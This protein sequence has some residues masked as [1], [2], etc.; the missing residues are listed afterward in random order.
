M[1][2]EFN[3]ETNALCKKVIPLGI[4][5]M[6]MPQFTGSVI[7][8]FSDALQTSLAFKTQLVTDLEENF[9]QPLQSFVKIQL[10]EFKEFKKQHEKCLERYETQ[11]VKYV[12]QVKTKE[13]SAI[14]EEAFRLYE[15]RKIYAKMSSQHV[16]RV[17]HF[18]SL[19]EHFLVERFTLGTLYHLQDMKRGAEAWA[20][21][22]SNV[23]SW[24]QWLID[25]RETCD[26]QLRQLQYARSGLESAYL[27]S[28]RPVRE[29]EK[30]TYQYN[31]RHSMDLSGLNQTKSQ[32]WGY[33]FMKSSRNSWSRR[34][35]FLYEG[36]FGMTGRSAKGTVLMSDRVSIL[37]CDVKPLIDLDR[38]FCFEVMCVHQPS[39]VLQAET[40]QEMRD[41][42][43][44]FEKSKRL[45]LQNKELGSVHIQPKLE[46][47]SSIVLLSS[48]EKSSSL[49]PLL[50]REAASLESSSPL[51]HAWG[52]PWTSMPE[53][54]S[55]LSPTTSQEWD[56]NQVVWPLTIDDAALPQVDLVGYSTD[57]ESC[58]K[59]LRSLFGGVGA[60]E[61]VL[62][63][64]V[65]VLKRP[66]TMDTEWTIQNP[67]DS[68]DPE[69]DAQW[70]SSPKEPSSPLG[71]SYTGKGY[72]TQCN[73]WFYSCVALNCVN[74]VAVGLSDI[75]SI[76]VIDSSNIALDL[77]S[78]QQEPLIFT[79]LM[80]RAHDIATKLELAMNYVKSSQPSLQMLYDNIHGAQRS[81]D[82]LDLT[83][84]PTDKKPR[85]FSF[86]VQPKTTTLMATAVAGG[87]GSLEI[88]ESP[89]DINAPSG[90]VFCGCENHLDKLESEIQLPISANELYQ[91]LF[92]ENKELWEKKTTGN[93]SRDLTMT[94]WDQGA[95]GIE[96][97]LKYI[98]PVNNSM[99]K[100]KE[101]EAIEKQV[102]EKKED[103]LC[104]VVMTTTKTPQLPYADAF[105][106]HLKYCITWVS[107]N[108]CKLACYTGVKFLKSILVK[109]IVNKAAMRGMSE[110]LE[111]FIPIIQNEVA[112]KTGIKETKQEVPKVSLKREKTVKRPFPVVSQESWYTQYIKPMI[113]TAQ[114]LTHGLSFTL[115]VSL[116]VLVLLLLYCSSSSQSTKEV[117]VHDQVTYRAVY[118]KDIDEGILRRNITS[119]FDYS[120]SFRLFLET[121]SRNP[122]NAKHTWYSA[123]H[124][125]LAI[126][127]LFS[128][129]RIALLRHDA[130]VLF[131]LMNE[132]DTQLLENEYMNWLMDARLQC[133]LPK[134]DN[135]ALHCEDVKHQL[136]SLPIR[137]IKKTQ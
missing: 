105:V 31:N 67:T 83:P 21:V 10:K 19:L 3:L 9:I 115:K 36:C 49:T 88:S 45:M 101:A 30:Y 114:D 102:I 107:Q 70:T 41:W 131:Q 111:I 63:A 28:A 24:K 7:Q 16:M 58:N 56:A 2:I 69:F 108:Q 54:T 4:D 78:T 61:I 95:E 46:I 38:R 119:A 20:K 1:S 22:E 74:T 112:Q 122:K 23:G 92:G 75:K 33:L 109:G 125:Q 53:D 76:R 135:Q 129:Q 79:C 34:W 26:H 17:L 5:S 137:S 98:I 120:D 43:T 52:M 77:T 27:N 64:F 121:N 91:L 86:P 132:V 103:G 68:L 80:N 57:L 130:L 84:I 29:L 81:L 14:R 113:E 90:P 72:I 62:T 35:F 40:E 59:E 96:R 11:L 123:R 12:S 106:P 39:F 124:R 100:L 82:A 89:Q 73:F 15:A 47:K 93:K 60:Q 50:V 8:S 71:F 99:V 13:P 118:I 94:C 104:Y 65:G 6:M 97:I 85:K 18:R 136:T 37:L 110:N 51:T 128:R 126:D 134:A 133:L 48:L 32:I 44:A 42:I 117:D 25:D 55:E 116:S 66:Y 87:S 127:L